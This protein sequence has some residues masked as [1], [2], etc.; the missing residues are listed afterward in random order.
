MSDQEQNAIRRL[1]C[2]V[3][4]MSCAGEV[5]IADGHIVR[6]VGFTCKRGQEYAKNEVTA[7][8]R[9]LTTTIRIAGGFLP[10]LPVVSRSPLPKGK[11]VECARYLSN[12]VV[13][14]PVKEADA[15][16]QDILG[17]GVDIIASR[18]MNAAST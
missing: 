4:P 2:I 6:M 9:V 14:A 17:L 16:C 8:K 12:I 13:Q 15:V 7:P 18:D 11:I 3:C 1:T 10:M 5:E